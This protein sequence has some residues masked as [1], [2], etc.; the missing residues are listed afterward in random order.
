MGQ[1]VGGRRGGAGGGVGGGCRGGVRADTRFTLPA[2]AGTSLVTDLASACLQRRG[3]GHVDQSFASCD[4]SISGLRQARP[5]VT[6]AHAPSSTFAAKLS[7]VRGSGSRNRA[8]DQ[9]PSSPGASF[10]NALGTRLRR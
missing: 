10:E 8:A 6:I 4:A 2:V 5:I 3:H 7:R 1:R 9:R